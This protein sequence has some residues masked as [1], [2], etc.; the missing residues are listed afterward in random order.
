MNIDHPDIE[1]FI[2]YKHGDDNKRLTQF[3]LSVGI[4]DRFMK[5]VKDDMDWDLQFEGK[6]Y[7]TVKARYLY[8]LI[9]DNMYQYNEPGVFFLDTVNAD[10]NGWYMYNIEAPNPCVT[11]DTLIL[12]DKGNVRIDSVVGKTVNVWNGYEYSEVVPRVTGVNQSILDIGFSTDKHLS[13]TPYHRFILEDGRI[14]EAKE[15]QIGDV[16]C[17]WNN[18]VIR[19]RNIGV[20]VL[21]ITKKEELENMVYCFIEPKKHNGV[22]NG[23]LLKNC[24]E[25]PL[26]IK[27]S[28]CLG[29]IKLSTFVTNPFTTDAIFDFARFI[30]SIRVA[31]RMLDDVLDT[32]EYPIPEIAEQVKSERRI[33]LG[34]TAIAD[35]MAML[36]YAYGSEESFVFINTIGDMLRNT[37]YRVSIELAKEKGVFPTFDKRMLDHG[38][39]S[40]LPADIKQDIEIY[41]LHNMALNCIAPTGTT[42]LSLG[43]NCSSGIE[44]IFALEYTRNVTQADG[45]L[46][47]QT[48]YDEAWL[49][50]QWSIGD[51]VSIIPD[52]F[53]TA[54]KI[55]LE[56][57]VRMQAILQKY[58]DASISKTITLPDTF[59]KEEYRSLLLNAWE[60]G[61][62]GFTTYNPKGNLAPILSKKTAEHQE[63]RYSKKR[64][65]LVPCDIHELTVNKQKMVVLVGK[66]VDDGLLYEVFLTMDNSGAIQLQK[67]KHGVI[68]KT[69][70]GRYDLLVD[71]KLVLENITGVFDDDCASMCR[72]LSMAMRHKIPLQ[73]IIDQLNK[74]KR[75]D[76]FAKTMARV[77]KGYIAD[78]EKVLSKSHAVCPECSSEL[79]FKEGCLT[80]NQCGWSKC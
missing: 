56:A 41:G 54:D 46:N 5:C 77:L 35:A 51:V 13:C 14:V 66:D 71:G 36:G 29:S 58:V 1:E 16:L 72:L 27:G 39:V 47:S 74:T 38:F 80:C 19:S 31:V 76:T 73:F 7:K 65:E 43:N 79:T 2:T 68:R 42:S 6:V 4:T 22:F 34:M 62:K 8:N 63:L 17:S 70:T 40:K 9:A 60:Q 11:G 12:T 20:S 10:N 59:T 48:V 49:K 45:T 67:A 25:Q 53:I 30:E 55:S 32:S 69:C 37:S 24:G 64:P 26:P 52:Y 23:M 61:L 50:Y 57:S 21:Y 3:N 75:F 18:P 28:C 44:P 33:G 15:L 78:G